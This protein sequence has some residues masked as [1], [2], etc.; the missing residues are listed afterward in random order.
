[1]YNVTDSVVGWDID[2]VL[3]DFV[4]AFYHR[5]NEPRPKRNEFTEWNIPFVDEHFH[6]VEND[7]GFWLGIKPYNRALRFQKHMNV[8]YYITARPIE[9]KFTKLW[10]AMNGFQDKPVLTVGA[11]VSKV[12]AAKM[13]GLTHFVDD[14][15]RNVRELL[16]IGVEAHLI[17]PSCI[18]YS[19]Q[20]IKPSAV[21]DHNFRPFFNYD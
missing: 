19:G 15:I 18:D 16:E 12:D 21:L 11:N 14:S 20:D 2:G 6:K 1:M 3:A 5:M 10:L 4:G 8:D 13:V 7:V 9:T 17:E